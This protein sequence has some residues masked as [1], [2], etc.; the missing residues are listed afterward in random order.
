MEG[1]HDPRRRVV[2]HS[3]RQD[4]NLASGL[5][6]LGSPHETH[7]DGPG[8]NWRLIVTGPGDECLRV[9]LLRSTIRAARPCDG[10]DPGRLDGRLPRSSNAT[11][12]LARDD[13][14]KTWPDT[15]GRALIRLSDLNFE[16]SPAGVTDV[17]HDLTIRYRT[18]HRVHVIRANTVRRL[19]LAAR[20]GRDPAFRDGSRLARASDLG[21]ASC[22]ATTARAR[23]TSRRLALDQQRQMSAAA[24]KTCYCLRAPYLAGE[25]GDDVLKARRHLAVPIDGG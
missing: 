6:S 15:I 23:P 10:L 1:A 8:V 18:H 19:F 12:D 22:A 17:T 16:R 11:F 2:V 20:R 24:A 5:Q 9:S 7:A 13:T 14:T 21:S 4:G 25:A 3:A